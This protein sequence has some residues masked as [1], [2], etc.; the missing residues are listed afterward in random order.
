MQRAYYFLALGVVLSINEMSFWPSFQRSGQSV[1]CFQLQ[2]PFSMQTAVF[3]GVS[4]N[5]K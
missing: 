4:S 3:S 2:M 5:A 1:N